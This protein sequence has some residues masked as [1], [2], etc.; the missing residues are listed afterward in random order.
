[1]NKKFISLGLLVATAVVWAIAPIVEFIFGITALDM[2]QD[3]GGAGIGGYL[4]IFAPVAAVVIG[5]LGIFVKP[6]L[7]KIGALIGAAG[8]AAGLVLNLVEAEFE[9]AIF[10]W[11]AWALLALLVANLVVILNVKEN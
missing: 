2:V 10:G 4:L 8:Y 1:M 11:G 5:A 6:T 7:S 3:M 9:L